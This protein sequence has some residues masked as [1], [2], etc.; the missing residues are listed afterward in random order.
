[1]KKSLS[2]LFF[3]FSNC[4]LAQKSHEAPI[5]GWPPQTAYRS[6]LQNYKD[7]ALTYCISVAYKTSP[8]ASKDAIASS[9]GID[10]WSYYTIRDE[11]SPI[12]ALT[13]RYLQQNY[14]AKDGKIRL[15]LMKCM[16]MYHSEDLDKLAKD[17]VQRPNDNWVKDNP[18][19]VNRKT[20]EK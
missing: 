20:Y 4:A 13:K 8:E 1:M 2:F 15:D 7:I 9:N 11:E 17:Y 6:Y 14:N 10:A 12:I 18:D 3:I 19:R 16:D 5:A